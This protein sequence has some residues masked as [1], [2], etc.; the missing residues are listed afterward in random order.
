[1]TGK[2]NRSACSLVFV[3]VSILYVTMTI[4]RNMTSSMDV[5]LRYKRHGFNLMY[6]FKRFTGMPLPRPTVGLIQHYFE[7]I[8]LIKPVE[9]SDRQMRKA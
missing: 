1:M 9:T 3:V 4:S 5:G 6:I 2:F 8:V 7:P